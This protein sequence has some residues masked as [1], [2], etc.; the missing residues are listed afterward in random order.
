MTHSSPAKIAIINALFITLAAIVALALVLLLFYQLRLLPFIVFTPFVFI[1]SYL[2]IKY[3]L[4]KFIYEKIKV[5]YKTIGWKNVQQN[6]GNRHQKPTDD[7]LEIVNQVVLEWSEEKENEIEELKRMASYRREFLGN[8]SHELKTPIFN[9]Q[10]YI[11]TLLDGGIHDE[12]IN[13]KFLKRSVKSINRMIAIVEDL[14]DIAKLES[15]ELTLHEKVFDLTRLTREVIDYMEMKAARYNS[16][17]NLKIPSNSSFKVMADKKRIRQ[18]LINLIDN[19]IK[20]GDSE[21]GLVNIFFYDFHDN[22]LVEISDNGMG[23][24]EENLYRVF[25]RFYR[26]DEGRSRKKGGSGLGLAIV[27]HILEAHRQTISVRSQ[28]GE[29]TTFSFTLRKG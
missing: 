19:G 10:G 21:Q 16:K 11:L 24:P 22:Y 26:T 15:G 9:I 20:Y 6:Q 23:I 5:I 27:K 2:A 29:G 12:S 28:P 1:F 25:E 14:E 13:K 4:E 3:S 17:I 18:V 7:I 8:V